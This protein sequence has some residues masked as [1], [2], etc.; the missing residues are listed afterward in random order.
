MSSPVPCSRP[1][2]SSPI[3]PMGRPSR[4]MRARAPDAGTA[5]ARSPQ[6]ECTASGPPRASSADDIALEIKKILGLAAIPHCS[7][8]R[9]PSAS[10]AIIFC[11]RYRT[12]RPIDSETS[13]RSR[14][15]RTR[16]CCRRRFSRATLQ[17]SRPKR[18]AH[19]RLSARDRIGE[20]ISGEYRPTAIALQLRIDEGEADGFVIAAGRQQLQDRAL[21]QRAFRQGCQMPSAVRPVP[22]WR[23]VRRAAPPPRSGRPHD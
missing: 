16:C 17:Q 1:G 2:C 14:T 7:G 21:G 9:P 12:V 19:D 5:P 4:R 23:S 20:P 13:R 8:S 6:S 15:A 11:S 18:G 10:P 3:S 22:G